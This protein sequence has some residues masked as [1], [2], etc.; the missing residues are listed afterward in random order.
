MLSF[1]NPLRQG[2]FRRPNPCGEVVLQRLSQGLD[3]KLE[4]PALGYDSAR[5]HD[6]FQH[7]IPVF[8]DGISKEKSLHPGVDHV[9][10]RHEV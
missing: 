1:N 7:G 6:R 5:T 8:I 9:L 10:D 2:L 4:D 3:S